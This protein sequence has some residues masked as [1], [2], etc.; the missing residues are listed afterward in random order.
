MCPDLEVLLVLLE[1]VG[2][3]PPAWWYVLGVGL[4]ADYGAWGACLHEHLEEL[5][6]QCERCE[7][8]Y[9]LNEDL[10][11]ETLPN[12]VFNYLVSHVLPRADNGSVGVL[13][14]VQAQLEH[15]ITR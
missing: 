14:A 3:W 7:G 4:Q 10:V 11:V 6:Q 9:T 5:G 8:L 2:S 1:R 12:S 13:S 15:G